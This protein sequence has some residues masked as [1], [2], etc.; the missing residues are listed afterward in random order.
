LE[1]GTFRRSMRRYNGLSPVSSPHTHHCGERGQRRLAQTDW[2]HLNNCPC[3]GGNIFPHNAVR[4]TLAHAVHQC[5][6]TSVVPHT[7]VPL[8]V[9]GGQWR[10]DV[11]FMGDVSGKSYVLDVSIVNTD[12]ATAQ[13]TGR[14]F[15]AVE[16]SLCR[17][18]ADKRALPIARQIQNDGSNKIFVPFVMSSAGGFGPAARSF[19]KYLYKISRDRNRWEVGTGQPQ[20]Q[21]TWNTLFA[22][23]YWDMRLSMA[24]TSMSAE[25]V[26]R[27][28]VRDFNLNLA[29]DGSRQPLVDPNIP[30]YGRLRLGGGGRDQGAF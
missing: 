25:V 11:M 20:I 6:A 16:A 21:S 15:G 22:S 4:D 18:E 8:D 10:A 2:E 19:L 7:E 9:P 23:T 28:I 14:D 12:S 30:A 17:C 27:I 26:G 3:L 1:E 24:C 5:G 29:S 13:R